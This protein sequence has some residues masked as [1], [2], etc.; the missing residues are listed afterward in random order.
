VFWLLFTIPRRVICNSEAVSGKIQEYRIPRAK[1][2]VIQA[3]SRQYLEFQPRRLDERVE[4]FFQRFPVVVFSYINL[5][6]TFYPLEM[7]EGFARAARRHPGWGL[8]LCGV[9]GYPEESIAEATRERLQLPDLSERVCVIDDLDHDEF[10]SAL[11][12]SAVFLRSPV[13]D[14]V[15]S[16]VLEALSLKVPVV[17]AENGHRPPG[18]VTYVATDPDDLAVVLDDVMARRESLASALPAPTIPD[19]LAVEADVLIG[20]SDHRKQDTDTCAA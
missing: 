1:I 9:A 7:L 2:D 6:P 14:G 12:R 8:V 3:F 16:S 11:S 13:S 18:V 10:L 15:C 17:A 20:R 5:R 19:T 4:E